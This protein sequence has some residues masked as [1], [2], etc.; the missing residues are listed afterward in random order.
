[1]ER[2]KCRHWRR[3]TYGKIEVNAQDDANN[4]RACVF[5]FGED[6][7]R[8]LPFPTKFIL[9]QRRSLR[10]QSQS[11]AVLTSLDCNN[12]VD[13]SVSGVAFEVGINSK[14]SPQNVPKKELWTSY[15]NDS[16]ISSQSTFATM[17][18]PPFGCRRKIEYVA[19]MSANL[20]DLDPWQRSDLDSCVRRGCGR[21]Q[22]NC[23]SPNNILQHLKCLGEFIEHGVNDEDQKVRTITALSLAA[24]VEAVAPYGIDSLDSILI[25]LWKAI[26]SHR[27][28]VSCS[29]ENSQWGEIRGEIYV[30][31]G[32][33]HVVDG[34][35]TITA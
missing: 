27:A 32:Q 14:E 13:G 30:P 4:S 35:S 18:S 8:Y 3:S 2:T 23:S 21:W 16:T 1:M 28:K 6:A 17:H 31:Q 33:G 9:Q 11:L 24:L 29:K 5:T 34:K 22:C 25:A 20:S 12:V 15:T 26:R 10:V 19:Q 7:V